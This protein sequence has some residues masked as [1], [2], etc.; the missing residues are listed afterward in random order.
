MRS[1]LPTA[2]GNQEAGVALAVGFFDGHGALEGRLSLGNANQTYFVAQLQAGWNWFFGE[3]YWHMAKGPYAGAAVRYWDLVQVHSGVQSH[4]LAGLVD[5]GWWFDFGQ[6]FID[7]RLS[8]VLAVAGFSSL[9]HALPGFAFLFSPLPGI[10]P[11]L[12]IGLIQVGL[13]L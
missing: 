4:N 13:W 11:W 2:L 3:Q 5:L 8:Q 7:V 9:P 10:S 12:P 1:I 6:W